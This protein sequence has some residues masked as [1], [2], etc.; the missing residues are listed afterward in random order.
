MQEKGNEKLCYNK[1]VL[2]ENVQNA[3]R[4][5]KMDFDSLAERFRELNYPIS[6]SNLRTYITQRNMSLKVLLYL[7]KALDVSMDELIGN[8]VGFSI[9]L[10]ENFDREVTN[11]RHAQFPGDYVVYFYPTRTN[12][13]EELI[14]ANLTISNDSGLSSTLLVPVPEGSSKKYIGHLILSQKTNTAFLP[15]VGEH[16]EIIHFTFNDPNTN[17]GRF[18]FC[19]A[20]LVSVSSGDAKR[21]PTLSRAIISE[22]AVTKSGYDFLSSNLRLNSKYIDIQEEQLQLTLGQFLHQE[23]IDNADEITQRILNAFKVRRYYSIEEQYFLNTFKNENSLSNVQTERLISALR[24]QSMSD[25]NIKN[26]RTIDARLYLLMRNEG[27]FVPNNHP[28]NTN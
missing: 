5:A 15:M 17:Q 1:N 7:S 4:L 6:S 28:E 13:P 22:Q 16:G 12:D 27:L 19:V 25:I 8:N 23:N 20:A 14:E 24:N 21:M 9:H 11:T 18:R 10:N 26:P 3:M 2:L